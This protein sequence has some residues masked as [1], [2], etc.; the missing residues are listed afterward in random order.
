MNNYII[1]AMGILAIFPMLSYSQGSPTPATA[2]MWHRLDK[3]AMQGSEWLFAFVRGYSN[4]G[5]IC[6][7]KRQFERTF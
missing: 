7:Y 3:T 1:T 2:L 6:R 5:P 4:P